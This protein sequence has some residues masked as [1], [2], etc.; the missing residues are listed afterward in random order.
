MNRLKQ[1]FDRLKK[2][3]DR[4]LV[5]FVTAGDPDVE[6]S[7]RLI[8]AMLE[9]GVDILEL[10]IPF[11]DP[12]ADGPV[13]QRSSLR[14][15]KHGVCLQTV[16]G[17][18]RR[19]RIFS[20]APLIIFSYYNPI[21]AYGLDKFHPD[22]Q[23]AGADGVLVVDLPL[24]ESNELTCRWNDPDFSFINLVAPTTPKD[25]MANIAAASSGFIYMVSKTGVTG[26]DGLD[27]SEIGEQMRILRSVTDLPV[28]VG[29]G[30]S[31]PEDV[32]AVA[33]MADGV[34]I[35][36]AFERLIEENLENP[37]LAAVIGDRT[38]A[39]KAKTKK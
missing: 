18:I 22:A 39:Y 20:N 8:R 34:V 9:N 11:S 31:T 14:A 26:S 38:A 29:F 2:T 28:C 17:M 13:I 7:L 35:G 33:Q 25:R 23:G 21:M 3:N 5:G 4:A 24:E 12:S 10:G 32:A 37:D 6:T 19:I 15:L 16:M 30:I 36:S 1:T 27:T